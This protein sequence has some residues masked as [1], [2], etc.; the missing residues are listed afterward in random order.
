MPEEIGIAHV[1][2]YL[3]DINYPTT[4]QSLIWISQDEGASPQII[5]IL[6]NCRK[7]RMMILLR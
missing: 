2:R 5:Q 3:G 4:R 6:K 7:K 1:N